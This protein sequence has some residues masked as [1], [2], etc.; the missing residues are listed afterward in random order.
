MKHCFIL[1]TRPEIIKLY[2]CIRFCYI[3]NLDYFII[4]TNQHYSPSMDSIFFEELKLP[5]ARYNLWIYGGNHGEMTWKMMIEIEKILIKEKPDCV[6]VQWDTNT[7][8]AWW[9]VASKLWVKLAHIEAGLRSYDMCMP[10][11]I[12]RI[13]IDHISD[14]LF[15]PTERQV[16]ILKKENIQQDKIY[17]IWNTVVD[18]IF[19]VKKAFLLSQSKYILNKYQLNANDYIL[20]TTHR[21]SNVDDKKNLQNILISMIEIQKISNKKI[22]FPI[23]PRTKNN[24]I[25]FWLEKLLGTFVI[26]EPVWFIDNIVLQS[27]A[28]MIVTDSWWI[29]EEACILQKKTLILRDTTERPETVEVWGAI[30]VWHDMKKI[31]KSFYELDKKNI[32]W[33]NPFWDGKSA[34][35]ILSIT[36]KC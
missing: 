6:Y 24:I 22:I 13:C 1:G 15:A 3:N 2:S 5:K 7:V 20:L 33:Y 31:V 12:N 35:K 14:Y 26:V 36:E 11:E 16:D 25:K 17:M 10:E 21:P 8:L 30:L 19:L 4:H 34:E 29:Q 32:D 9:L 28:Y 18:A 23:H 27:N